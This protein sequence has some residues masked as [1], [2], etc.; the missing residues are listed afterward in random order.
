MRTPRAGSGR[1]SPRILIVDD[2]V[3]LA[4]SEAEHF[5]SL[6]YTVEIAHSERDALDAFTAAPFDLAIVDLMME[7]TDAGI[8]LAHH[9]KK[10]ASSVPILMTS[11]LTG[12]TGMVF[13]LAGLG[14]RRW[15]KVDRILPKPVR[16]EQLA[17]AAETLLGPKSLQ[18]TA[19]PES[20]HHDDPTRLEI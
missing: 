15:I 18:T 16:L 13:D 14:E 3:P 19:T 10:H 17:F 11:D 7:T 6:G 8:V 4:R 12:E 1:R 20:H 9:F 5:R 2:I